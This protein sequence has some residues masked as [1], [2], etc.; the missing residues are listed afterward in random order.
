MMLSIRHARTGLAAAGFLGLAVPGLTAAPVTALSESFE[1]DGL[2]SRYFAVGGG[3]NGETDF[4]ARREQFSAGTDASGGTIDG[5]FFWGA[6]DIDNI[7]TD[8]P[9]DLYPDLGARDGVLIFDDINV[10]GLSDLKIEMAVAQGQGTFEPDNHFRIQIRFDS[11]EGGETFGT[12]EWITIGGF[13]ATSTN[14]P[15]RYFTGP[16]RLTT[17]D[18][19][20]LTS[21]LQD[22]SWD[23]WGFGD[24][25]DL[26]IIMNSNWRDEDYYVDNIRLTGDDALIQVSASMATTALTEPENTPPASDTVPSESVDVTFTASEAAPAGG[27]TFDVIADAWLPRTLPMPATVTIPEGQTSL[28]VTLDHIADFAFTGTKVVEARFDSDAI[29]RESLIFTVENTTPKPRVL[30]M[31]VQ[32]VIP[33]VI[34]ADLQGDANGD[35]GAAFP[36]DQFVE[37]VNFES[38]PVD[39]SGWVVQDDLGP[40]HQYPEGTIIPAGRALVTFGG[41]DPLGVFGGADVLTA[42]SGTTGFAFNSTRAEIAGL[43]APFNGEMEIIDLPFESEILERT[44]TL[45]SSNPAFGDTMS[46]HRTGDTA[47]A[48]FELHAFIPGAT[49][50]FSPGAR[51][52][53]S[54]YFTPTNVIS[55]DIATETVSENGASFPANISLQS[56]APAGGLVVTVGSPALDDEISVSATEIMI[57][58]GASMA[59]FTVSPIADGLLDGTIGVNVVVSGPAGSDVLGALDTLT[60]TDIDPNPYTFEITEFLIDLAGTGAD[61]NLDGNLEQDVAD[62][63]I[64]IVNRSGFPV[65]ID[66]WSILVRVGDEFAALQLGHTFGNTIL[67]DDGAAVIFGEIGG[68]QDDDPVFADAW[69]EDASNDDGNGGLHADA[70]DAVFVDLVNKFGFVITSLEIPG[71]LTGQ[72]MSVAVVDGT[73]VLHLEAS[74]GAS[75]FSPGLQPDGTPFPGNGRPAFRSTFGDVEV[76]APGSWILDGAWG[77]VNVTDY[78]VV[79]VQWLQGYLFSGGD[80]WFYA[81][82]QEDWWFSYG[83]DW[84]YSRNLSS[85]VWT[86]Y[87]PWIFVGSTQEWVNLGE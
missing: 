45:D 57:P 73:P 84:F 62:Q 18:D 50:F 13:R 81:Y 76:T 29:S 82:G 55:L 37:L 78:P 2:G 64:E 41:G 46:L 83:D 71:D 63:F 80:D 36:G 26:R 43:F 40:R 31:E 67:A 69:V 42:S 22:W 49:P 74:A 60:V 1:T 35:G 53:G 79:Y 23:I 32:N 5:N 51:V 12:G 4:F 52:D 85:P 66:D 38:F 14:T 65:L 8:L 6:S 56:P 44:L 10:A 15:G 7:N 70:G 30:I 17:Q 19:P 61:P 86:G 87:Y 75:I 25:M 54:P 39:I 68:S 27:L 72:G 77:W 20:R 28:T 59:S 33:G 9:S 16:L 47:D 21:E 11:T 48:P 34:A 24:T 3:D 58:A